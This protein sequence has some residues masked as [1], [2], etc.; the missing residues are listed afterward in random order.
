[1]NLKQKVLDK[2]NEENSVHRKARRINNREVR[3][4]I[5][6]LENEACSTQNFLPPRYGKGE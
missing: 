2:L 4:L 5:N 1:M 3:A 6:V